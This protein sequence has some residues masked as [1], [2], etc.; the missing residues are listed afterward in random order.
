MKFQ[1]TCNWRQSILMSDELLARFRTTHIGRKKFSSH[2]HFFDVDVYDTHV[3]CHFMWRSHS[4]R[5]LGIAQF[6]DFLNR[7]Q[8][9][10]LDIDAAESTE[11]SSFGFRWDDIQGVVTYDHHK[12]LMFRSNKEVFVMNFRSPKRY[13]GFMEFVKEKIPDKIHSRDSISMEESIYVGSTSADKIPVQY[14]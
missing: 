11:D 1:A 4:S 13:D 8:R 14:R 7:M 5:P 3:E 10:Q 2:Q 12:Q 6:R 9:D